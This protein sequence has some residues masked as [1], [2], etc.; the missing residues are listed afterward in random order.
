MRGMLG[1]AGLDASAFGGEAFQKLG[2]SQRRRMQALMSKLKAGQMTP[3]QLQQYFTE[4]ARGQVGAMGLGR[5][6]REISP[7]LKAMQ[8][9]LTPEEARNLAIGEG[10]ETAERGATA[11]APE[12]RQTLAEKQVDILTQML[13]L[14]LVQAQ[15]EPGLLAD[16]AAEIARNL[17]INVNLTTAPGGNSVLAPEGQQG[18]GTV[19]ED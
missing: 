7:W 9:G 17:K 3:E 1:E 18:A 8:D 12:T 19:L 13:K 10:A 5:F 16:Q 2:S 4:E 11:G 6:G 14:Q 15:R